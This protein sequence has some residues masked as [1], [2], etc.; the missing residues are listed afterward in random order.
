MENQDFYQQILELLMG[1]VE[2]SEREN[3]INQLKSKFSPQDS[4]KSVIYDFI[5]VYYNINIHE[6]EGMAEKFSFEKNHQ[7]LKK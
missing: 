2:K 1:R 4:I 3:F 5:T 7:T 6:T